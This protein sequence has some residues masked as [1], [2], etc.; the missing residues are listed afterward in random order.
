[1]RPFLAWAFGAA[2]MTIGRHYGL[3]WTFLE[4]LWM[5]VTFGI[6]GGIMFIRLDNAATP[7]KD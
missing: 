4:A 5:A 3:E 2:S 1:M 6:V 7:V